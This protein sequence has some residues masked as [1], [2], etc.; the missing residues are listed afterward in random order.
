M[1]QGEYWEEVFDRE[2][3]LKES[4]VPN[5]DNVMIWIF[6]DRVNGQTVLTPY[7]MLYQLPEGFGISCCYADYVTANLDD[8]QSRYLAVAAGGE[9][10][11]LCS[12]KGFREIGRDEGLVVYELNGENG[13]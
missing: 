13:K 1:A 3:V 12:T 5:F 2:C 7:Q 6:S 4:D 11:S 8:L 9:V 10:D